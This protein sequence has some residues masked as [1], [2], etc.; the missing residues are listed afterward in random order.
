M[1]KSE[2][3][4]T[5]TNTEILWMRNLGLLRAATQSPLTSGGGGGYGSGGRGRGGRGG[6]GGGKAPKA[7]SGGTD[8]AKA[9]REPAF[10]SGGGFR[11][12][13]NWRI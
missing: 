8:Y 1:K 3:A 5:P 10:G 2:G 9:E 12:L 7:P 11:G 6:G 4:Y 13:I